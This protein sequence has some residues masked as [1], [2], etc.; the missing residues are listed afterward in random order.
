MQVRAS[1][2]A[3]LAHGANVL[4]LADRDVEEGRTRPLDEV[5]DELRAEVRKPADR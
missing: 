4:A 3:G 1:G 2:P 5:F